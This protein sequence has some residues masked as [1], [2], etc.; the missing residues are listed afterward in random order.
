M[1][2]SSVVYYV[3]EKMNA[4]HFEDFSIPEILKVQLTI[5]CYSS[6]AGGLK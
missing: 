1:L 6:D 3:S 2:V 4:L 5:D